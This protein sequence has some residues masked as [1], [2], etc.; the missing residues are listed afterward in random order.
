MDALRFW[1]NL[2]LLAYSCPTKTLHEKNRSSSQQ[3]ACDSMSAMLGNCQAIDCPRMQTSAA[4][5]VL[6]RQIKIF[7]SA[8]NCLD[9]LYAF[10]S[11]RC[12]FQRWCCL[13]WPQ[14]WHPKHQR[15]G[16]AVPAQ[17]VHAAESGTPIPTSDTSDEGELECRWFAGHVWDDFRDTMPP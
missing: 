14:I 9:N 13:S 10:L 4:I 16:T 15:R 12:A 1:R 7:C 8:I 2:T 3:A 17:V 5:F 11:E 6:I